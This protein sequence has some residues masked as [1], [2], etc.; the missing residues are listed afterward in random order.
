MSSPSRTLPG[1]LHPTRQQ[2]DELDA[3]MQRMLA[4]P[5][6][7]ADEEVLRPAGTSKPAA[8]A[9][10][11]S[12]AA[13]AGG[14]A[15]APEPAPADLDLAFPPLPFEAVTGPEPPRVAAPD[16]SAFADL[17][18]PEAVVTKVTIEREPPPILVRVRVAW[19]LQPLAACN[20]AFDGVTVV[21]GPLGRWLATPGGRAFL[22]TTGLLLAAGAAGWTLLDCLG[23]IW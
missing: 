7:P 14:V 21:L 20:R 22:G 6:S 5:V 2:L 3:L 19:W 4:L 12:E 18:K 8:P 17:A 16:P 9:S 10:Q 11:P 15:P 1:S 13:R 23:W